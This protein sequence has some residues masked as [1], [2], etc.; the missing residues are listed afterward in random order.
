MKTKFEKEKDKINTIKQCIENKDNS[1]P[2]IDT[3]T[4]LARCFYKQSELLKRMWVR[5]WISMILALVFGVFGVVN[6]MQNTNTANDLVKNLGCILIS[7]IFEM[8]AGLILWMQH[9]EFLKLKSYQVSLEEETQL[10]GVVAL[11]AKITTL[12]QKDDTKD[13]KDT[14]LRLIEGEIRRRKKTN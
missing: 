7:I 13:L 6:F 9:T 3:L 8:L 4:M 1:I 12:D 10:W 5:H 14:Y 11:L 2:Q